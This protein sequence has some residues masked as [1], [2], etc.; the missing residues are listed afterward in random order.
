MSVELY[1]RITQR[2]WEYGECTQEL[3]PGEIAGRTHPS[4]PD[5][6][7]VVLAPSESM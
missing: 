6:F 3:R 1:A 5:M 7:G 4:I 2:S